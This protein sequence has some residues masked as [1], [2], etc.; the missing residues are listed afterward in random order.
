M[1]LAKKVTLLSS[2]CVLALALGGATGALAAPI[3]DSGQTSTDPII[4]PYVNW[5]GSAYLTTNAYSNVTS[6]NNFFNDS[7]TV[8]NDANSPGTITVR[9]VNSSGEQVGST[10]TISAGKSANLDSIPWNSG[11]Y[12]LQAKGSKAGYYNISID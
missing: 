7:P 4:V 12:T 2:S 9:I 11:T 8:T 1:N 6:S 5:S 3:Q 10:K